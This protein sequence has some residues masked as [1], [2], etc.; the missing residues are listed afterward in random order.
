MSDQEPK[1]TDIHTVNLNFPRQN[2]VPNWVEFP[3]WMEMRIGA[4][5]KGYRFYRKTKAGLWEEIAT[6]TNLKSV[7]HAAQMFTGMMIDEQVSHPKMKTA[8]K[9][10]TLAG[11]Q[12]FST[13]YGDFYAM[14][15]R[16]VAA[17]KMFGLSINKGNEYL[18]HHTSLPGNNLKPISDYFCKLST[19]HKGIKCFNQATLDEKD[20]FLYWGWLEF[21]DGYSISVAL[22][23]NFRLYNQYKK[24][25]NNE[26]IT[27]LIKQK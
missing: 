17:K 7:D 13:Y 15:S 6:I 16:L 8:M 18:I 5:P 23:D 22:D 21:Y 25:Y 10:T 19:K 9:V 26:S 27:H 4:H 12:L 20:N 14:L 24:H 3:W 2:C 1:M 11:K